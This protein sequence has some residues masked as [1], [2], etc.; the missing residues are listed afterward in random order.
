ML[1]PGVIAKAE[2]RHGAERSAVLESI[3]HSRQN[4]LAVVY[5]HRRNFGG[6]ERRR[7]R[8]RGVTA[9]DDRHFGRQRAHAT[10][11]REHFIGFERVHR[12]DAD[13]RWTRDAQ[14]FSER[15]EA[16]IG[17]RHMMPLRFERRRDVLHAE[18]LD[19][20]ERTEAETLI[21]RHRTQQKDSHLFGVRG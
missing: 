21:R 14:N 11:Q 5:D 13:Q 17:E 7:I 6:K 19:A 16:Q 10:N 9:N 3:G 1:A 15:A 2:A 8:R 20:E 18:R 4:R 12:R